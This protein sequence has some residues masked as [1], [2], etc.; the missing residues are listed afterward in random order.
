MMNEQKR[1]I[2]ITGTSGR[3]GYPLAKR[4]AESFNVVGFDRRAPSH[5]PPSAECLYVDLTSETS[6]Q[7]GL[8]AI[9]ELHGNRLAAVIHL[10]AYYD[11]LRPTSPLY[12]EITV[13][14]TARLL[15][16][17]QDFEVEQF[18]FSSTELVH[19]PSKPGQRLNEDSPLDPQWGYPKSKVETEKVI[20]A[21]RGKI[22]A[23]ILRIAGVYDDLCNSIPLAHQ[24]QRMYE[25]DIT[26]YFF[27]GDVSQGRQ[28]F[29]HNDDVLDAILRAVERRHELP[30]E[31]TLL[32]GEPE[33]P[34]FDE[35]QRDFGR[36]IHGGAAKIFRVPRWFAKF[37]AV[38]QER[39][40]GRPSFIKA[41]MV[42]FAADN[43]ELDITRARAILDWTPKHALRETL[44]QMVAAQLA[45]P[46]AF[47]RENDLT[48]PLWLQDVAPAPAP[49]PAEMD[50][51]QV[52][53]MAEQLVRERIAPREPTSK[54]AGH[55]GHGSME[56]STEPA[57]EQT[58][59]TMP[60][61]EMGAHAEMKMSGMDDGE[62]GGMMMPGIAME[63]L[64][65]KD[66]QRP[67]EELL[68]K[69][70]AEQS[71]LAQ[72]RER[73]VRAQRQDDQQAHALM[74]RDPQAHVEFMRMEQQHRWQILEL[75]RQLLRREAAVYQDIERAQPAEKAKPMAEP[76]A[77]MAGMMA[78]MHWTHIP[79]LALG[80]WLIAAPFTLGYRSPPLTASDIVSGIVIIAFA[81]AAM[82]VRRTWL[83]WAVTI[84]GLWLAFAPLAFSA[85]DAA[86]Y[87][88]DTL[89][90]ALVIVFAIILGMIMPMS[91]PEVPHAWSYNP[92]TWLQRAPILTLAFF[93]FFLSRY[94]A[95]FQLGQIPWA[96][97]PI[98]GDGT[99]QVLTSTV[100]KSFPISDAGLGAY[101]YLVELLSGF[102]G[103]P[104]RWRTMPW[105]VAIFGF[106]VVPLGIVSVALIMLQPVV[107]GAWCMACLLSA[108]F[109][110]LMVALSLDE[111]IAMLLFMW[112]SHQAGKSL[113][114][115][116][117]LGGDALAQDMTPHRR[118]RAG[119]REM[120][121]GITVPWNLLVSAAL[122]AWLMAAPTV[123]QTQGQTAHSDHILG[124]LVVTVAIVA[125]AE[126]TRAARFINIAL[127]LGIIVLPW[128]FG[129]ATLPSGINDLI[130]GVLIIALSIPPGKIKNTYNNWNP[131][132]L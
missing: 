116:F 125:F 110:L 43:F 7:R 65:P 108:L 92:S 82:F 54:P 86:A 39:L 115:T 50:Q 41:W 63:E 131:L 72:V 23:V 95:A 14:G 117:W 80:L 46:V 11:F 60:G 28:A 105:M 30:P 64:E 121:W 44:P 93:S 45:D 61:M 62:S 58:G 18:I 1:T 20:H 10:A 38:A 4:L 33:S 96:W 114:R 107:V 16:R 70:R 49:I 130:I 17:L 25:R 91:G 90:G 29:V 89:V 78:Q 47:Y 85:P 53:Q 113:W 88:N 87:A 66:G 42:D 55:S 12:D 127:A 94:M 98:F 57:A 119:L 15:R 122:G 37:G 68:E 79:L 77:M 75:P 59:M 84:V 32:I 69:M 111:V 126:V 51:H 24:M 3:I 103:D 40:L 129:G 99:V 112:Q 109:M 56:M 71:L 19:A 101:I 120:F 48:P 31:V 22:P 9:R 8:E 6:T 97:D 124:A 2:L 34:S 76:G 5:P 106:M 52:L 74:E 128:L 21:G 132:I 67:A 81:M 100:S 36:L 73:E 13:Q 26:A 104:R 118:E 83:M 27:P 35:L 102:M 123:F